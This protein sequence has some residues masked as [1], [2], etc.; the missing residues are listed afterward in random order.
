ML[1][2]V[3]NGTPKRAGLKNVTFTH[4]RTQMSVLETETKQAARG[5]SE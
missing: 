2:I 4:T 1:H 5:V 3:A